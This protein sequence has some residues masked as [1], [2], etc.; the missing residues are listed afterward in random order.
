METT[1]KTPCTEEM[2]IATEAATAVEPGAQDAFLPMGLSRL[3][4]LASQMAASVP[5]HFL[6]GCFL[7]GSENG[8]FIVDRA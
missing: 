1:T 4:A 5:G 3:S 6:E 8:R 2:P 7:S